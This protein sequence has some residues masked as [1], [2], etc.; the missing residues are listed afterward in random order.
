METKIVQEIID[1]ILDRKGL[2]DEWEQTSPKIQEEIKNKW[3]EI[4][5]KN[6]EQNN[7]IEK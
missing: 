3:I 7:M 4:V 2:G 1:D 5:K 6:I